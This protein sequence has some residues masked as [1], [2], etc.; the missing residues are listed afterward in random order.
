MLLLRYT[1]CLPS[2]PSS[3]REEGRVKGHTYGKVVRFERLINECDW[4]VLQPASLTSTLT[5][6]FVSEE[7]VHHWV[8]QYF[9][10][11]KLGEG[12]EAG[13]Y[14]LN[15]ET[16]KQTQEAVV[17]VCGGQGL[18]FKFQGCHIFF[19]YHRVDWITHVSSRY[20]T[21]DCDFGSSGAPES[22]MIL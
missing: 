10:E 13:C 15:M 6:L 22:G 9:L 12:I 14:H 2:S 16:T 8:Q 18:T 1:C 21:L 19:A 3:G 7:R 11:D 5:K 17:T 20:H 4:T